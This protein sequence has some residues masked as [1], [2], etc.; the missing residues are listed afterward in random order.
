VFR[1]AIDFTNPMVR[2]NGSVCQLDNRRITL[3]LQA[4]SIRRSDLVV[5]NKTVAGSAQAIRHSALIPCFMDALSHIISFGRFLRHR[6]HRHDVVA[7][8]TESKH[9]RVHM[10]HDNTMAGGLAQVATRGDSTR[11]RHGMASM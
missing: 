7:V 4:A 2:W 5:H 9:R 6:H 8:C 1:H 11:Q 10:S 3:N